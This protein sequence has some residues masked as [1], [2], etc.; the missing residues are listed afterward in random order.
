MSKPKRHTSPAGVEWKVG[1]KVNQSVE[2]FKEKAGIS[3]FSPKDYP[4]E[5]EGLA[6]KAKGE[7]QKYLRQQGI[8]EN[9]IKKLDYVVIKR[10]GFFVKLAGGGSWYPIEDTVSLVKD[11]SISISAHELAHAT[12]KNAQVRGNSGTHIQKAGL[13]TDAKAKYFSMLNEIVTDEIAVR[14]TGEDNGF[15]AEKRKFFN[16]LLASIAEAESEK[17]KALNTPE[18]VWKEFLASY[19]HGWTPEMKRSL[20]ETFS[21]EVLKILASLEDR[22]LTFDRNSAAYPDRKQDEIKEFHLDEFTADISQYFTRSE[23]DMAVLGRALLT[24]IRE[25]E[26]QNIRG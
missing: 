8:E 17:G 4:L 18:K 6:I 9:I 5:T 3:P 19:F 23:A 20:L 14:A 12:S 24:R 2:E 25:L 10:G 16:S 7:V 13:E 21:P 26:T 15:H 22:Y 11:A 1:S